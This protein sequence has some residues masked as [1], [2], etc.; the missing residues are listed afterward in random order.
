MGPYRYTLTFWETDTMTEPVDEPIRLGE[1]YELGGLLGRGGMADVRVGRDLRLGRTVAVKQ[2]RSD[3]AADD[4]FQAWLMAMVK[5]L[6][7]HVLI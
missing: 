6:K 1:R 2:L 7:K 4:T 3:L 5:R